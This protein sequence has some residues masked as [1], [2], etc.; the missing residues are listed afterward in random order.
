VAPSGEEM[1]M[2]TF[3]FWRRV[4]LPVTVFAVTSCDGGTGESSPTTDLA[5]STVTTGTWID[6]DGYQVH[7]DS[8][9]LNI[10]VNAMLQ[11]Q[12][13]L[14]GFHTF[15]LSGMTPNCEVDGANPRVLPAEFDATLAVQF[16]VACHDPTGAIDVAIAFG[17]PGMPPD[18]LVVRL[19]NGS[20]V[21][22][23][24]TDPARFAPVQAGFHR[25]DLSAGPT[26]CLPG[27]II[28]NQTVMVQAQPIIVEFPVT[29]YAAGTGSLEV[30]LQTST[31]N[32]GDNPPSGF[33]VALDD[34]MSLAVAANGK[35]TFDNVATGV[36]TLQV[37][38]PPFCGAS[39]YDTNRK[40]IQVS[41]GAVTSVQFR[42]LCIG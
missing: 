27:G 1:M 42:E 29:C 31:F 12:D 18:N 24:G 40:T 3:R 41:Q 6:P 5:L 17:G 7:L 10:G 23:A 15:Q 8:I 28:M 32:W 9:T 36:H 33:R 38:T 14:T 13:V 4:V 37:T 30:T 34:T 39:F 16:V 19:D 25:L 35:V 22:L 2:T 20:P 21:V 11:V 26:A